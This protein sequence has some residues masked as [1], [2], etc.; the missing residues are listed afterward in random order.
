MSIVV[1]KK[2]DNSVYVKCVKG[3]YAP[4]EVGYRNQYGHEVISV[5]PNVYQYIPKLSFKDKCKKRL[6]RFLQKI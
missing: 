3:H 5:M 4:Y 1:W 2:R 6:I